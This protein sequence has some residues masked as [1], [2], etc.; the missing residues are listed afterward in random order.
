MKSITLLIASIFTALT[1]SAY[2]DPSGVW[3][4]HT[5]KG[6]LPNRFIDGGKNIY[7]VSY[8]QPFH[9]G[10][11]EYNV[12]WSVINVYDKQA[13]ELHTLSKGSGLSDNL[14]VAAEYNPAKGYLLAVYHDGDIDLIYDDGRVV[15]VPGLRM[16]GNVSDKRVNSIT[17][18]PKSDR[19]YLATNFGYLTIND[20]KG[21]IGESRIYHKALNSIAEAGDYIVAADESGRLYRAPLSSPRMSWDE[22]TPVTIAKPAYQLLPLESGRVAVLSANRSERTLYIYDPSNAGNVPEEKRVMYDIAWAPTSDGYYISAGSRGVL[23]GPDGGITLIFPDDAETRRTGTTYDGSTYWFLDEDSNFYSREASAEGG[24]WGNR[25]SA[26]S[27]FGPRPLQTQNVVLHPSWGYLVA[28]HGVSG[29]FGTQTFPQPLQISAL[30]NGG[31]YQF[32]F[33]DRNEAQ[34]PAF[35]DPFGIVVDPDNP[36]L[37]YFGSLLFGLMR[38]NLS[39]PQDILHLSFPQDD[40]KDLPGF[41]KVHDRFEGWKNLSNLS[42]PV[43]DQSGNLWVCFNDYDNS[44]QSQIWV[45]DADSRRASRNAASYR[46]MHKIPVRG[47]TTGL[48]P[49]VLPL[50]NLPNTVV[51]FDGSVAGQVSVIQH[52][53]TFNT[54]ADDA[55]RS[56]TIGSQTQDSEGQPLN[57]TM[58]NDLYEDTETGLVW[59]A[60][61]SGIFT[62]SPRGV[63]SGNPGITQLKISRNDGTGLADYL[64]NGISIN[65]I[66]PDP[67]GRKWLATSGAGLVCVAKDGREIVTSCTTENSDIPSD[68]VYSAAYSPETASMLVATEGGLA[69]Y[70]PYNVGDGTDFE[71]IRA[72]PNPVRPEYLGYVTIDGLAD[73]AIVK[74]ADSQG[75][76]VR[77]LGFAAN[78]LVRW[79]VA[80][81]NH[82]RVGSGVYFV[83]ASTGPDDEKLSKVT[84]ILVVN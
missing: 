80:D 14:P 37:L 22:Y 16:A 5:P 51:Y 57:G 10:V 25:S 33:Q 32:G 12:P 47:S 24:S 28:N 40:W 71:N 69:E 49:I 68:Q 35:A 30:R 60:T 58:I 46:P 66:I 43:L 50:K 44:R 1:A 36:D 7:L 27:T 72:Y 13:D 65:K 34:L 55:V 84:K 78:G 81:M 74:I 41:V 8:A 19:V 76:L 29:L 77:E 11:P 9:E 73:N 64:L 38:V 62:F 48:N 31:W 2:S 75:H 3:T 21:E 20:S 56:F 67:R 17:F 6:A 70:R 23:I 15:N 4:Y 63:L 39:D 45:W 26:I 61:E 59:A 53:G 52:Q 82:R 79:D 18:A 83:L 42:S 54:T